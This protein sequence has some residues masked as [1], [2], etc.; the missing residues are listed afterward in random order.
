[1]TARRACLVLLLASATMTV[2][3]SGHELPVYP[4]YYPHE[5]ELQA[6]P[7]ER[8]GALLVEGQLHAYVGGAPRRDGAWPEHVQA[9]ESLGSFVLVRLNP[10]SPHAQEEQSACAATRTI[11]RAVADKSAG[12]ITH[13]YPVTPLHG[14]YLHHVDLADV[15][16]RRVYGDGSTLA[17]VDGL[18]VKAEGFPQT[19]VPPEWRVRDGDW[20]AEVVEIALADLIDPA[21]VALNGWQGPPWIRSG[22]FHA[23]RLLAGEIDNPPARQR[24]EAGLQRLEA[25]AFAS[26]PER[27]NL[28]RDFVASLAFGCHAG[29]IGYRVKREFIN[30]EF[31][32][33][34]E[35]IAF[36]AV[37]GLNAPMF[38]RTVKLKDFPWNGWLSLGTDGRPNAAWN[39]IAGF[40]DRFGRLLWSAVGDPAAVPSP[41]DSGWVLNRISDVQP[42]Q[43]Q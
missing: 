5:I 35:N 4:S 40:N 12:L 30:V 36:D 27:I 23:Y 10:A 7:P 16:K 39:P 37:D 14:D 19:A 42:A 17:T 29:V 11:A 38:L 21:R 41:Y 1:M 28:E 26:P 25:D 13:P 32:A 43:G 3:R 15:V 24:V 9:I 2:A 31:S 18:K 20:D 6:V 34:I 22:W 33:G 8:A